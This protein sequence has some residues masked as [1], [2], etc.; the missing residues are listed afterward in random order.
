VH[1]KL[2]YKLA[3]IWLIYFCVKAMKRVVF[4]GTSM[5]PTKT[6]EFN[7]QNTASIALKS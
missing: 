2:T 5:V 3:P 1:P 7:Y 4:T 6:T